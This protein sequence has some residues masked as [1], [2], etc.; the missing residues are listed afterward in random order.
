MHIRGAMMEN[1]PYSPTVQA[2]QFEFDSGTS[3]YS[4][5]S[6]RVLSLWV[7]GLLVMV[8]ALSLVI[9]IA[10]IVGSMLVP[11]FATGDKSYRTAP[12]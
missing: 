11:D 5:K 9:G 1:N 7:I 2:S 12:C 4:L 6:T 10:N 3:R 8:G